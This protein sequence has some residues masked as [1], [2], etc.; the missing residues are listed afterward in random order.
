MPSRRLR[1]HLVERVLRGARDVGERGLAFLI[2]AGVASC[3]GSTTTTGGTSDASTKVSEGGPMV[4]AA[5]TEG[6]VV[7]ECTP[8][9]CGVDSGGPVV[10]AAEQVDGG[11]DSSLIVE[12][13]N[14]DASDSSD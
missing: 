14:F 13:A 9:Q 2:T 7:V 4:E 8:A 10:E 3:G 1:K 11:T 6:G 12:A 5:Q